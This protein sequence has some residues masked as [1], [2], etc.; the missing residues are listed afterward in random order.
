MPWVADGANMKEGG[1][2][3]KGKTTNHKT[4]NH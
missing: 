2:L 1:T 3:L 4:T